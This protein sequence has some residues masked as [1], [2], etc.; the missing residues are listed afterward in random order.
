MRAL[1][2]FALLLLAGCSDAPEIAVSDTIAKAVY[3]ELQ[4]QLITAQPGDVIEIPE[5]V[6][7]FDRPL[8]LDGI[9]NVTLRGAGVEKSVL[10]FHHQKAGAEGLRITADSVTLEGFTVLDTK[11]DAIKLQDCAGITI[12]NVNTSWRGGADESNGGYGLYPVASRNV[13]IEDCEASY[14]S[15][16]G[17]YV[18]QCTDVVVRNCYAYENV[19]GIEIENCTKAEVY[20]NRSENNTGGILVFD[21][22]ELPA[23]N[24]R[25]CKIYDNEIIENNHSNFAPEGNIV[26]I[27][28]PGTGVIILAAKEVEV[29]DNRIIGHKTIGTAIASYHITEK[30]WEDENYDP[31][32]YDVHIHGNTYE[33]KRTVP[34]LSKDFGKMVNYLFPGKPQDILYDGIV[35]ER[36]SGANPMSICIDQPGEGLRFANVDAANEFEQVSH[37]LSS[38]RCGGG[39]AF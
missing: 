14:A 31:Y 39:E 9:S 21:L 30:P 19:A 27:V 3:T 16:A 12:R 29:Y 6:H 18:G 28:P 20:N 23:G 4:E 32:S 37:D 11:G 15:D 2:F 25:D 26:G 36:R 10:S 13:L 1:T 24:G 38:Y 34:D 33:R 5:G 22:P 35:D 17:I 8:S 7:E